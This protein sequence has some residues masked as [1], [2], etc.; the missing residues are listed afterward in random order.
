[1]PRSPAGEAG[2]RAPALPSRLLSGRMVDLAS[3]RGRPA[4]VNFWA[5]W[6]SPCRQEAPRLERLAE[7]DR[8]VHVLGVDW[9]DSASDARAF[10]QSLGLRYPILRDGSGAVGDRYGITG[11]PSTFVLDPQGR[12]ATVLRGPQTS[13]GLRAALSSASGR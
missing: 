13:A 8:R 9:N 12:I 4:L 11:L 6:C 3:L 7:A 10:V 5:S 2:S 1:V